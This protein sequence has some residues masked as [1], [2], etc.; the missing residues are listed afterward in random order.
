M[1]AVFSL[2]SSNTS[3]ADTYGSQ[4]HNVKETS[5]GDGTRKLEKN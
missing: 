1:H 2:C 3:E 5:K 4:A